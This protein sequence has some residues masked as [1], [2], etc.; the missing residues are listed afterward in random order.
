MA[1]ALRPLYEAVAVDP[2][3]GPFFE[4]IEAL[5][6]STA[7]TPVAVPVGCDGTAD[8]ITPGGTD[9]PA[10][11]NGSYQFEW[12]MQE[13]MDEAGADERDARGNDGVFTVTFEDGTFDMVWEQDPANPCGGAYGI[14]GDRV[15]LVAA[16]DLDLWTCGGESLGKVVLDARWT[17]EGDQLVFTDFVVSPEPDVTWFTRVFLSRPLTKI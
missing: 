13:L 2:V 6:A 14:D 7:G 12:T 17:L 15:V 1:S 10:A 5:K 8:D 4:E 9:D 3:T 16:T 11:L